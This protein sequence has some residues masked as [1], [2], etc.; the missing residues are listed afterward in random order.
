MTIFV[1]GKQ[2]RVKRP[3]TIDGMD[4]DEFIRCNADPIWLHQNE[5]W[6]YMDTEEET[7]TDDTDTPF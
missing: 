2:K 6:E 1:N 4:V 3:P 5:M 7:D